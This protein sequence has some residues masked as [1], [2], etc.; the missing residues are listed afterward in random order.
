MTG[1][2]LF[3]QLC[4]AA[5]TPQDLTQLFELFLTDEEKQSFSAR[6]L[7]I[8]ALLGNDLTQREIAKKLQVS[9]A[10]IT[11]GSNMLKRMEPQFLNQLKDHFARK[12]FSI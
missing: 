10:K 8:E 6:A 1:W 12:D 11:R 3:I 5:R 7:I 4:L 9:I 2:D